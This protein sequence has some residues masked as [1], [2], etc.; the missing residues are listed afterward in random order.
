LKSRNFQIRAASFPHR[1]RAQ[2]RS[3]A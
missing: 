3:A 1:G 2:L